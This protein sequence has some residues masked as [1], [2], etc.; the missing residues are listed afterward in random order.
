MQ[1]LLITGSNG[2]LGGKLV[3]A[4]NGRYRIVGLDLQAASSVQAVP[5][6]YI[7][8]DITR[9][10][11]TVNQIGSAKP[12]CIIHT[13]AFTDVDGCETETEKAYA[14]NVRG[15]EHV[16]IACRRLGIPLVHL[17]TDYVFDGTNGPYAEEAVPHPLS[18][19]GRM[20]FESEKLV[21]QHV[22]EAVVAR[23]M[24]LFGF[25]PFVR[26]NFVTWLIGKLRKREGVRIV[27]D[28]Y[29]TPT[30][31]DDLAEALLRLFEKH[32]SGIFH[33]AGPDCLNRYDFAVKIA[34]GFG[35][36]VK[37]ISETTSSQFV[38]PA[39]RPMKSGLITSKLEMKTGFRFK[40]LGEALLHMK[41]QM[42]STQ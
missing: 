27:N 35:L 42:D 18:A 12:D 36:D 37:L 16:A 22:P 3:R 40:P 33:T 17:S 1:T 39:P 8:G 28:Q 4:A 2:L 19:Y 30:L 31:A 9:L 6:D 26:N 10:E 13:A 7:Q 24:V 15:A 14:V 23:T 21:Q 41:K 38:Q 34:Q 5:M 29:G 25:L 32:A 20:K 11:K